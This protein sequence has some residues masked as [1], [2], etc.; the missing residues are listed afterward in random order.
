M[1]NYRKKVS[2]YLKDHQDQ[3]AIYKLRHN[4]S[5]TK[6]DVETLEKIL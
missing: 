5:L 6:K 3:T 4:K 2:R 1:Q